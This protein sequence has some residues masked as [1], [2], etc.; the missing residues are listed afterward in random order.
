MYHKACAILEGVRENTLVIVCGGRG[1]IAQLINL[2][3]VVVVSCLL[4][5]VLFLVV[6]LL[7]VVVVCLLLLIHWQ[8]LRVLPRK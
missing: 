8:G 2:G 3:A 1:D 6:C 7:F 5:F 4:L